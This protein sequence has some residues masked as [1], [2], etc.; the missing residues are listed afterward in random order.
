M[1]S[2]PQVENVSNRPGEIGFRAVLYYNGSPY[3]C[4]ACEQALGG[5]EG[6]RK[7]EFQ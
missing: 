5:M 1:E 6:E 7:E 2:A 4:I 3:F